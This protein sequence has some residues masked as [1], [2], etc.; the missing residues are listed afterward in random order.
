[1]DKSNIKRNL[2][3]GTLSANTEGKPWEE[4]IPVVGKLHYESI[5]RE[6]IRLGSRPLLDFFDSTK[7]ILVILK[8]LIFLQK[9]VVV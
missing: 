2:V 9:K 1:M 8:Q 4:Y 7:Y 5:G 6:E 3:L